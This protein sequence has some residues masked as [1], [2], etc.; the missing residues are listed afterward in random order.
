M[1]RQSWPH[2]LPSDSQYW[3]QRDE[4]NN[5]CKGRQEGRPGGCRD[6]PLTQIVIACHSTT[7]D[8]I[9]NVDIFISTPSKLKQNLFLEMGKN[10]HLKRSSKPSLPRNIKC[11]NTTLCSEIS[12]HPWMIST[13]R[14]EEPSL[15]YCREGRDIRNVNIWIL[16]HEFLQGSAGAEWPPL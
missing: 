11:F 13:E 10:R 6:L 4:I 5:L 12:F 15:C 16:I 2:Y 14:K 1:P 9:S 3:K 8:E 7:H